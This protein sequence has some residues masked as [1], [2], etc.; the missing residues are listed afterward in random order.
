MNGSWYSLDSF[1]H[2]LQRRGINRVRVD[3]AESQDDS[4]TNDS[5][6]SF[7]INEE[8]V[9]SQRVNVGGDVA[10]ARTLRRIIQSMPDEEN[11]DNPVNFGLLLTD[12]L[13]RESHPVVDDVNDFYSQLSGG[14]NTVYSPLD[15]NLYRY[16]EV[17]HNDDIHGQIHSELCINDNWDGLTDKAQH[18]LAT[19]SG[20]FSADAGL[21]QNEDLMHF[22]TTSPAMLYEDSLELKA[23]GAVNLMGL[24]S[25]QKFKNNL[26][27]VVFVENLHNTYLLVGCNSEILFYEFSAETKLP[28]SKP[29]V[30]I[31]TRPSF[32]SRQDMLSSV[33]RLDPHTINSVK[34]GSWRGEQVF[35]VCVDDGSI[36]VWKTSVLESLIL[37]RLKVTNMRQTHGIWLKPTFRFKLEASAWSTDFASILTEKGEPHNILVGS[38]NARKVA[39]Y[40]EDK[41]KEMFH[42]IKSPEFLHN[43]PEVNIMKYFLEN[44]NHIVLVSCTSI[45]GEILTLRFQFKILDDQ[46]SSFIASIPA[47]LSRSQLPNYCWTAK[48]IRRQ[49][50]KKVKSLRA[51]LGNE[52]CSEEA[53]LNDLRR[54]G[55]CFETDGK[56][57]VNQVLAGL[58]HYRC[59]VISS[60]ESQSGPS[61]EAFASIDER[62]RRIHRHLKAK[63]GSDQRGVC[64]T[65]DDIILA[66][67]TQNRAGI[68][69]ADSLHCNADTDIVF[70]F[71][72]PGDED[73]A[74]INRISITLILPSLL[75]WVLVSQQGLVSVFR[76]CEY[77]GIFGIRQE[78]IFPNGANIA[79]GETSLRTIV[80]VSTLE[81]SAV[82]EYPRFILQIIYSDGLCLNYELRSKERKDVG[83]EFF[84]LDF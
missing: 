46:D 41:K 25:S 34:S 14:N 43:I 31:E 3:R 73:T 62:Y 80:G 72:L 65:C 20:I 2:F 40:Y 4:A 74:W 54:D 19:Q 63:G 70:N 27:T 35:A 7:D 17:S 28:L 60:S 51:M 33:L 8:N 39:L 61:C 12:F 82:E 11:E 71:K 10:Q 5:L 26:C 48:P 9:F 79:F 32:T 22:P 15:D 77:K 45:S 78:H 69:C 18:L 49:F 76:F 53:I 29:I 68:F 83:V 30:Q 55:N 42:E 1:Q 64:A 47:V 21:V 37:R 38:S 75:A 16:E 24:S 56:E 6:L 36:L 57:E 59:P 81:V 50:F 58:H 13:M 66:V 84:S 23:L 52:K 67:T 44:N